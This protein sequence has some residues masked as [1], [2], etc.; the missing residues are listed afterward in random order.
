MILLKK[1]I[2]GWEEKEKKKMAAVA[3]CACGEPCDGH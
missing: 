1:I 3:D 2:I